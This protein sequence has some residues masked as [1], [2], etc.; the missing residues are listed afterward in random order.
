M[1]SWLTMIGIFIGI[2]AVVALM[3]LGQ[4]LQN[5]IEEQ[6]EQLGS[7]KI[8]ISSKGM[9]PPGSAVS[10]SLIL[11]SVDLKIIENVRGVEWAVGFLVK[12]GQ[13][14]F[15][16]DIGIGFA[17][18]LSAKDREI[19]KDLPGFEVI[20]GRS[21]KDGDKF[22]VVVG[23]NHAYKDIWKRRVEIGDTIEIEDYDFKVVGIME[24]IGNPIDDG[25][26]HVPKETLKEILN[27]GDEE[28]QILAKTSKGFDPMDVADTIERKLR[29]SRGE[30]EDQETF[31][32]ATSEQLLETFTDIFAVIQGVLIGIAGISL[33]VGGVGIANTMYTSVLERTKEI[34]TMKAIGAK[35][36][37]ILKL[38]LYEAGLLGM[39]GGAI[40]IL[41]GIGLG[42]GAEYLATVGLGTDL[43]RAAFPWY[44][45]IGALVFSFLI[46]SLSG[47]LPAMQ[48]SKLKPVDALRY[49]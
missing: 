10:D 12:Q 4:G 37:D 5:A 48:A 40:G 32:V 49:E 7:D 13:A 6:F 36:S 30:K 39:I 9:G 34:G 8:I 3:S 16:G 22:K 47:V 31:N 27:V 35:N 25:I 15:K 19:L 17:S 38:F 23:Y 24:K 29:K 28:S 42:K 41:I 46:G 20:E 43:L 1:R 18:G 26:M 21:L 33:L 45:I 11:T 2:A 44:L 14:K